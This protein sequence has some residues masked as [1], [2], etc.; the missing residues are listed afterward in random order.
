MNHIDVSC[1]FTF[2]SLDSIK[3]FLFSGIEGNFTCALA[4][5]PTLYTC[6]F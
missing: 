2:V 4:L 1:Q 5:F 3:L 6:S